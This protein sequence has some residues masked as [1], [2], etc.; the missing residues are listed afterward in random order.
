VPPEGTNSQQYNTGR[1]RGRP[2]KEKPEPNLVNVF[3]DEKFDSKQN[4][5]KIQSQLSRDLTS[6]ML[7]LE[8]HTLSKVSFPLK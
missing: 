1:G 7:E 8:T 6:E 5:A 4:E 2:R 3:I